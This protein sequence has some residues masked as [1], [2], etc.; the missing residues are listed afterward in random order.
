[1]IIYKTTNLINNK[2]YIGKDKYNNPKYFGSG[3]LIKRAIKKY[4]K[5]NF[6]K[7]IIEYCDDLLELN[8]KEIY[9]I[10]FY[11]NSNNILYNIT[12]GGDGGDTLSNHPDLDIIKKK[13]GRKGR[14][15][16]RK[17][18]IMS[19]EQ[20]EKISISLKETFSNKNIKLSDEHK[21]KI[22]IKRKKLFREGKLNVAKENNGKWGKGNKIFVD[23]KIFNCM[24]EASE[25]LNVHI[26]TIQ[27]RLNSDNFKNYYRI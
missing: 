23:G 20:K 14:T 4:G 7:E 18:I 11:K 27:Y 22:S 19:D 10:K 5:N 25:E 1:M 6:I 12:N 16:N 24:R 13:M 2:I 9:W 15:S 17:G 3:L 26:K 8:N 21:K